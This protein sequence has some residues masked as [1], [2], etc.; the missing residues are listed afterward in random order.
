MNSYKHEFW[1]KRV[2]C[3]HEDD[4]H[5]GCTEKKYLEYRVG[6]FHQNLA[7]GRKEIL[8]GGIAKTGVSGYG[9]GY[10][11]RIDKLNLEIFD[12]NVANIVDNGAL[13]MD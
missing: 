7:F 3:D 10:N 5:P 12:E 6:T 11:A 1:W 4:S 2:D 8:F 13:T 9:S